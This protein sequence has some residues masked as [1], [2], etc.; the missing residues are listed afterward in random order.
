ME[1]EI[2]AKFQEHIFEITY[3]MLHQ[4]FVGKFCSQIHLKQDWIKLLSKDIKENVNTLEQE[5]RLVLCVGPLPC[6][7][8]TLQHC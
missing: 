7:L 4:N 8:S 6:P 1:Q 2:Q 5:D 3:V